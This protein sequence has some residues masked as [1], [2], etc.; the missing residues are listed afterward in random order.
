MCP[1]CIPVL[2]ALH[3]SASPSSKLTRANDDRVSRTGSL[4]IVAE[5]NGGLGRTTT[6][7]DEQRLVGEASAV[8]GFTASSD[9][10]FAFFARE[11][12]C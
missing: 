12:R 5:L 1:G 11:V 9:D 8:E 6:G 3:Q 7:T 4:G 10:G 2:L